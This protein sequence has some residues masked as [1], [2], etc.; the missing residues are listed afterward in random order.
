MCEKQYSRNP[1]GWNHSAWHQLIVIAFGSVGEFI[2]H[3]WHILEI[4]NTCNNT[5]RVT[6]IYL[7]KILFNEWVTIKFVDFVDNAN[8]RH[9]LY[10]NLDTSTRTR[11]VF[12]DNWSS[13]FYL[14][15]NTAGFGS[16][17]K[18]RFVIDILWTKSQ[19]QS[20]FIVA[21][22]L[23]KEICKFGSGCTFSITG[24]G[25]WAKKCFNFTCD[26]VFN[27]PSVS[28]IAVCDFTIAGY[29]TH[30]ILFRKLV[31]SMIYALWVSQINN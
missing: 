17:A 30:T 3:N 10:L 12:V 6:K 23:Q 31:I 19:S 11:F 20:L 4:A 24:L 16:V 2:S 1:I 29:S 14:K 27:P 5:Y 21:K 13:N 28:N 25:A 8:N 15:Q 22:G 26:T 18:S 9:I 7:S